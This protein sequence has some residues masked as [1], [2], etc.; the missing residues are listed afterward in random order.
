MLVGNHF[1]RA[2]LFNERDPFLQ[3]FDDLLVIQPVRRRVKHR[4]P[5]IDVHASPFAEQRNEIRL[6]ALARRPLALAFHFVGMRKEQPKLGCLFLVEHAVDGLPP[7]AR[8][9]RVV[10]LFDLLHL[11]GIV[12]HQF[13]CGVDR[14]EAAADDDRGKLDLEIGHGLLLRRSGQLQRHQEVTCLPHAPD[15]V[16]LHRD[17]CR[18]PCSGRKADVVEPVVPGV[19][20]RDRPAEPDAVIDPEVRASDKVEIEDREEILV[21]PDRDAILRNAAEPR[22]HPFARAVF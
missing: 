13:G 21:P 22:E 5:V 7:V 9:E 10:A 18:L 4:L 1:D 19:V 12:R 3:A 17:K 15:Q 8:A 11:H 16:V 14:R 20:H 2:H 6:L